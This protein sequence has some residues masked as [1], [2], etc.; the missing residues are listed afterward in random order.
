MYERHFGLTGSPFQ[1]SPDASFYFGQPEL[2]RSR[3]ALVPR[4]MALEE[5]PR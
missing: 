5:P 1:L 2:R 3:R 4:V